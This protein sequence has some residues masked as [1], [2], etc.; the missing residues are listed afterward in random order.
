M[1]F[2]KRTSAGR[3]RGH[4]TH[5]FFRINQSLLTS[6]P[7]QRWFHGPN[8][9]AKQMEASHEPGRDAFH[10]VLF[11]AS[12]VSDAVERVPTQWFMVQVHTQKRMAALHEPVMEHSPAAIDAKPRTDSRSS[13]FTLLE[14]MVV[15]V[16]IGIMTAMI[17]PEMKGTYEDAL[18]R[19][20][21][22]KLVSVLN[23]ASSRAITLN[24]LHRVRLDTGRGKFVLERPVRDGEGGSGFVPVRD[25]SGT[26]GELDSRISVQVHRPGEEIADASEPLERKPAGETTELER[27]ESVIAFHP[28]GTADAREILLRDRD[29]FRLAIRINPTTS[30]V[31]VVELER[32]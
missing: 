28:D 6:P 25:I 27:R 26:E 32:E 10:R 8:A 12:Q 29:G 20:T 13:G 24:Q 30:R 21:G 18:L 5:V 23:L 22:R 19:S 1:G 14:L 7:T 11:F 2:S 17:I 4:E 3:S 16:L 31:S 9:C 15:V